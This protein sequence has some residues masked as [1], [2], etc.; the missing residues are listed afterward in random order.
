M[1]LTKQEKR[2]RVAIYKY[3]WNKYMKDITMSSLANI[4]KTTSSNLHQILNR[5]RGESK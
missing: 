4:L 1:K 3:A 5:K 2:I